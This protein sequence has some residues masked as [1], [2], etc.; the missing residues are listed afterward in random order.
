MNAP[1]AAQPAQR[2]RFQ[3][4]GIGAHGKRAAVVETASGFRHLQHRRKRPR[5][6][7][8]SMPHELAQHTAD[9]RAHFGIQF[10][11]QLQPVG[12]SLFKRDRNLRRMVGVQ[13]A[14]HD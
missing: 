12:I 1:P 6:E 10:R 11:R 4:A 7:L 5:T 9:G 8:M 3:F 13:I 14:L 2:V